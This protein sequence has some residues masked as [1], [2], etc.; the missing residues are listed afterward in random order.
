[1]RLERTENG[2]QIDA[3]ALGPLLG[4]PADAVQ[5]LMREG[6]IATL[7]EEGRDADSGRHRLTF[8]HG[9]VRVRLT[10]NDAGDVLLRTRT[11]VAP[12]P[13]AGEPP[14]GGEVGAAADSADPT[15]QLESRFHARHRRR[16]QEL[17]RLAEMVEDLHEDDADVPAGLGRTLARIGGVLEAHL[18]S[19][20][21]VVFPMIRSGTTSGLAPEIAALRSDHA[22]L[23][24]DCARIREITRD[25]ALPDGACTSWGTLYAGLAELIATLAEHLRLEDDLLRRHEPAAS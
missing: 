4:V 1:M 17:R 23:T 9:G 7:C 3:V 5:R 10:V 24:A 12:L 11:S 2:F 20:E 16:L 8:R 21:D 25:F 18:Q 13:A 19:A 14:S 22:R 15:H 6:R